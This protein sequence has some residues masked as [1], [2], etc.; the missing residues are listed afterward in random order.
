MHLPCFQCRNSIVSRSLVLHVYMISP[1]KPAVSLTVLERN[2][3]P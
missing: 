1:R 2:S 3:I